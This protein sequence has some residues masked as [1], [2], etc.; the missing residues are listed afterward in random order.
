[1]PGFVEWPEMRPMAK[2][3]HREWL[4]DTFLRPYLKRE[5]ADGELLDDEWWA[6]W[7]FDDFGLH[8]KVKE[9]KTVPSNKEE[10]E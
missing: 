5:V 10:K 3:K 2:L 6:Q 9:N 8:R 4:Y 7:Y 1:M